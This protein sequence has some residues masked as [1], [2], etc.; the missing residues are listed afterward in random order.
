MVT[1]EQVCPGGEGLCVGGGV[2]KMEG[3]EGNDKKERR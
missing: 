2:E 1:N 3:V